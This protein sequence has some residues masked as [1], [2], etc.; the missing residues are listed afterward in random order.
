[1]VVDRYFRLAN[2]LSKLISF[3]G[4]KLFWARFCLEDTNYDWVKKCLFLSSKDV[5]IKPVFEAMST[6]SVTSPFGYSLGV[7]KTVEA[8]LKHRCFYW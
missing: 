7:L 6:K 8:T 1:M 3:E 4:F 2:K 5:L